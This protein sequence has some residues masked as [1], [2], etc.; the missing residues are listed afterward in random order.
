MKILFVM[1]MFDPSSGGASSVLR[2]EAIALEKLGHRVAIFSGSKDVAGWTKID[3][4]N[5]YKIP[6]KEYSW[7]LQSYVCIKNSHIER[8]FHLFL[9]EFVPDVVHFHNLYYQFPFS[10]IK[11]AHLFCKKVFYTA[12]D[13]MPISQ[14]KLHHFIKS[15]LT[16]YNIDSVE[17]HLSFLEQFRQNGKAFNPFRNFFI[18]YY[19]G[20]A[21]KI[22]VVSKEQQKAFK[23]NKIKNTTILYNG[24]NFSDWSLSDE[25]KQEIFKL[26]KD[27]DLIGYG[28]L[29]FTGR[30]S[31]HK[32]GDQIAQSLRY[33]LKEKPKTKMIVIGGGGYGRDLIKTN[34]L[35]KQTVVI[36]SVPRDRMKLFYGLSDLVVTP[37]LCLETFGMVNL[38]AMACA[39]P[40]V[41]T[42]F[43]GCREVV[44]DGFTGFVLN[45]LNVNDMSEKILFLL[46]NYDLAKKFGQAGFVRAQ[47]LFDIR[48]H[49]NSLL[50]NY[51]YDV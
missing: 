35:E 50:I 36:G 34:G 29:L 4:I 20:Y 32:G 12:H 13:V 5:V 17:Y 48:N 21:S 37:S 43:G 11:I 8:K 6:I 39:R 22:F 24:V 33:I 45:P 51:N 27:F 41:T 28:V 3:G 47:N 16:Q 31:Y 44:L 38:E 14:Q 25:D 23:Q 42:C 1:N 30:L 15:D 2:D 19:L 49:V 7:V 18:R 40:V 9:R 26:K 10:L 46:N